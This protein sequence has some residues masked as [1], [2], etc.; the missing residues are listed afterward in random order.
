MGSLSSFFLQSNLVPAE[1]ARGLPLL[2]YGF[3]ESAQILGDSDTIAQVRLEPDDFV[4][5]SSSKPNII[6]TLDA[7]SGSAIG[8]AVTN[9]GGGGGGETIG[10]DIQQNVDGL[11]NDFSMVRAVHVLVRPLDPEVASSCKV[12]VQFGSI[13]TDTWER[14]ILPLGFDSAED[15]R[16]AAAHGVLVL[17]RGHTYSDTN[18]LKITIY[19]AANTELLLALL[20]N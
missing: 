19:Q 17:P 4:E 11:A 6:L 3:G 20:G 1:F 5:A 16:T 8:V 7:G 10:Y 2:P 9:G 13:A 14:A 15:D 12:L 18:P